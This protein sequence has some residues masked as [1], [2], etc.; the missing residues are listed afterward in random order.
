MAVTALCLAGAAAQAPPG[1]PVVLAP[2]APA[3]GGVV[4]GSRPESANPS[5]GVLAEV[6]AAPPSA[7]VRAP[8]W[9]RLPRHLVLAALAGAGAGVTVGEAGVSYAGVPADERAARRWRVGATYGAIGG[10][11]AAGLVAATAP[12]GEPPGT[13]SF[14]W[15]RANTPLLAGIVAV[16]NLDYTS[17]RYFRARG[18]PEWLLT[19]SL[20]DNRAAFVSTEVA[21]AGAA[22]ALAYV[23]HRTGH[24]GWERVFMAG[25]VTMGGVSAWANYRY[26]KVGHALF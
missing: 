1:A 15:D 20:V 19:N 24:H 8:S 4:A 16:Q 14:W 13:H 6:M 12:G 23:L 11:L 7:P 9:A 5:E 17:T 10:A 26:P 25:Y 2:A 3:A 22:I 18:L 21:S